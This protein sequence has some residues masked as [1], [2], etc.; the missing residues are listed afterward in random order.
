MPGPNVKSVGQTQA[1]QQQRPDLRDDLYIYIYIYI[2]NEGEVYTHT[3]THTHTCTS[4]SPCTSM[5]EGM[6]VLLMCC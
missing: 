3:H 2:I 6:V 1:P 4:P 5:P